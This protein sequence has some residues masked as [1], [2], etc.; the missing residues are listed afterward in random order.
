MFVSADVE[1]ARGEHT[2][3]LSIFRHV[4]FT[5]TLA[6]DAT[7]LARGPSPANS[8]GMHRVECSQA[9]KR[10]ARAWEAHGGE[11][12]L[13]FLQMLATLAVCLPRAPSRAHDLQIKIQA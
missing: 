3:G 7:R 1:S 10:W 2:L 12:H 9:G 8:M 4:G 13:V 6:P 11:R 5:K